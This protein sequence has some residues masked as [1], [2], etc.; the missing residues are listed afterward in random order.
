MVPWMRGTR[1]KA[2]FAFLDTLGDGRGYFL[3]LA[4]ADADQ[5]AVADDDKGGEAGSVDHP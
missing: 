3:G 1:K 4:V 2:F 5:L